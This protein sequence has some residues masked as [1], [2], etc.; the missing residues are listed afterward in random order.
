MSVGYS[1]LSAVIGSNRAA[2]N[3]GRYMAEAATVPVNGGGDIVTWHTPPRGWGDEQGR[4]A[5]VVVT[6]RDISR[7]K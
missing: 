4:I 3:A 6:F 7:Q 5:G 1:L 2:R